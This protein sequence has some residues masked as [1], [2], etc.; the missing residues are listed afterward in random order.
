M[1]LEKLKNHPKCYYY[2]NNGV[3]LHGDCLEIM[4]H[5]EQVDLVLTDPPYGIGNKMRGGTWGNKDKYSDL[6]GWDQKICS[7]HFDFIYLKSTYQIIWGANHYENL[8]ANRCWLVWDKQNAV[9]TM[10][11]CELAWTNFDKPIKRISLPVGQHKYGH[12]TEKPIQ[13]FLWCILENDKYKLDSILD[14][15]LG[16]GTTAVACE[17]LKR[18][19]IGI[20]IEEKYAEIAAKRIEAETKQLKLNFG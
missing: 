2:T 12:P 17:R 7:T 13:L 16:S 19:W 15:F 6:R 18:K 14:P 1:D 4:P 20:E 11:D 10:S 9:N 3:L 8:T 5:L